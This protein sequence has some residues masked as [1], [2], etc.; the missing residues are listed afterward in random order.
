MAASRERNL[1]GL[2]GPESLLQHYHHNKH[3]DFEK[4]DPTILAE[5]KNGCDSS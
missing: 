5:G 3:R 1:F 4:K 2:E